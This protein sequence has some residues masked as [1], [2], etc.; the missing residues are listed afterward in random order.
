MS[1]VPASLIIGMSTRLDTK[2][3][4][5][6][7]STGIF[8][9]CS[10]NSSVVCVVSSLVARPRITST[11][12]MTGTGFMKCIPI[13]RSGQ[14]VCAASSVIEMD[15]VLLARIV[16]GDTARSS[17]SK[18]SYLSCAFSGT[19]SITRSTPSAPAATSVLVSMRPSVASRADS[20]RISRST[21]RARFLAMVAI[22]PS[23]TSA[24]TSS[25]RTSLPC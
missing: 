25:K 22:A 16:S 4:K 13:T 5:S 19:A 3:G 10:A 2:P 11:S 14:D 6:L 23:R 1:A 17:V 9:N 24:E 21:C 8:P 7:T 18:R 15:E 12:L 20:S